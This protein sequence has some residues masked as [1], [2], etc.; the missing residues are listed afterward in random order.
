MHYLADSMTELCQSG[1]NINAGGESIP[2]YYSPGEEAKLQVIG[3][4][5]FLSVCQGVDEF[6]LPVARYKIFSNWNG[7]KVVCDLV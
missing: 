6:G 3:R 7:N 5:M 1:K 2:M 4:G